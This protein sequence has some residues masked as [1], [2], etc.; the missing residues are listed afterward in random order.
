MAITP[1]V[2]AR[3]D[4]VDAPVDGQVRVE[5]DA[6]AVVGRDGA[7]VGESVAEDAEDARAEAVRGEEAAVVHFGS[8]VAAGDMEMG[9]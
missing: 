1:S 8:Q 5:G 4:G 9:N 2:P 6:G 3:N 7:L